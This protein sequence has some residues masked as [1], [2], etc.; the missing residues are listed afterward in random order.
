MNTQDFIKHT[1]YYLSLGFSVIP[2]GQDKKPLIKWEEYQ[3]RKPTNEEIIK[4]AEI[5]KDL[6]IGIVT[7]NISDI[8][9]VDIEAGGDTANLPPTVI[10]KT[11]GGGFHFY[12]K[13]PHS[14]VKNAVRIR[15]KTD[16]RG[17]GGY[18]IA[19]PSLHKSG[20][21]Y[22]WIVPPEKSEFA[23]P[24]KWIFET[25][26]SNQ[27][28]VVQV[29]KIDWQQFIAQENPE[30]SRNSLAARLA[31]KLLYHLPVDLWEIA[32]W[33]TIKEWN[34]T[35]N[36]PP[37]TESELRGVWES[38]KQ[39][40]QAK[41]LN[42]GQSEIRN[43]IAFNILEDTVNKWLLLNDKGIIKVLAATVIANKL[44][45]DPVWLFIVTASGG[46]KTELIRGLAK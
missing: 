15:D 4:W 18:V 10:S 8:V 1:T 41:R 34:A 11:G 37:L 2:V 39:E 16:I 24:P 7:G 42:S 19:P 3:K 30:G 43:P 20:N 13:H 12:Y 44:N 33:A 31:G 26:N 25:S 45:A 21:R 14:N 46:T 32:G 40:E 17:D 6:N 29:P 9:V 38:I 5:Y 23:E 27:S 22:E 36:K 28:K 35:Q